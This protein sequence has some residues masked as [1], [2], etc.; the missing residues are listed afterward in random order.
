[1][2]VSI[3]IPIYNVSKYLRRCLDTCLSQTYTELEIIC[4]DDGSTDTSGEIAD[5]YATRDSRIKVV[6]KPNGGLP[7]ARKV[8]IA[9]VTGEYVFHLDGDDDIPSDTI[10]NLVRVAKTEDADIVIGDYYSYEIDG[11]QYYRDSRIAK[12]LTGSQYLEFILTEGLFNIWG[13]LIRISLYKNNPIQIPLNISIG[14]DLIAMTQLAYYSN[15]VSV[16]KKPCYNYY[17]RPTSM[18]IVKPGK[19]G[20]LTDRAI[21][22]VDFITRFL[23]PRVTSRTSGLLRDYVSQFVYTYLRSPYPISL[24]KD[25]LKTL[26]N[27]LKYQKFEKTCFSILI[28][29]LATLNLNAAKCIVQLRNFF[30]KR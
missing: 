19:I 26:L 8:G 18:S 23:A 22:A 14:E 2:L 28:C 1:M 29:R 17:V 15:K 24:R 27:Y 16:C 7:S 11:N 30:I 3:I 21:Y 4:V 5:E 25:E 13:K 12:Q 20:S 6:H 10:E 9:E